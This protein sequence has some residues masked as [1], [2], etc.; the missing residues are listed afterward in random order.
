MFMTRGLDN[1]DFVLPLV[2]PSIEPD[3]HPGAIYG[4]KLGHGLACLDPMIHAIL[5]PLSPVRRLRN[6]DKSPES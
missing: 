6:L 4:C 1:L 3:T 2:V 5:P